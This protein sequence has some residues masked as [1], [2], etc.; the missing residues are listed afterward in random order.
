LA[1]FRDAG[2]APD[3]VELD[4]ADPELRT[5]LETADSKQGN[6]ALRRFITTIL[7]GVR[8]AITAG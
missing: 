3:L 8:T 5:E 6:E 1:D 2:A 4:R 7:T